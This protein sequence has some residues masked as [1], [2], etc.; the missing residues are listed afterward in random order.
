[1]TLFCV[2]VTG[3]TGSTGASGGTGGT[4]GT[5]ENICLIQ[6]WIAIIKWIANECATAYMGN[7]TLPHCS[8]ACI[9]QELLAAQEGLEALEAQGTLARQVIP[10]AALSQHMNRLVS[11]ALVDWS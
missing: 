8:C 5:G 7:C 10:K 1:M 6:V 4:G 9:C 3:F 2:G 11:F